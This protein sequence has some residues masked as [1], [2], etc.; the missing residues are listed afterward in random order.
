[1]MKYAMNDYL[2]ID[3]VVDTE[4]W[5]KHSGLFDYSMW[6]SFRRMFRISV[7]F[8]GLEISYPSLHSMQVKNI[9]NNTSSHE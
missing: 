6:T 1:M 4:I 8:A 3:Q 7:R 5:T 9:F 2:F